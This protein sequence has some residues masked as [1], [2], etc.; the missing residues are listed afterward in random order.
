[1]NYTLKLFSAE[2]VS[3]LDRAAAEKRYRHA[4]EAELGDASLVAPLWS[5]VQRL[6]A[7]YGDSPDVSALTDAERQ[8]LES[9]QAAETAARNAAF[10]PNRY[11]EEAYFDIS[12]SAGN[13]S[14]AAV[15]GMSK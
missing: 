7:A 2:A 15:V 5:A 1:M 9:W 14:T 12:V 11:M 6:Y 10:G 13:G 4:L 3:D 8:V